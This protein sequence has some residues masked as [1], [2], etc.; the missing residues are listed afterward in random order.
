MPR[1]STKILLLINCGPLVFPW[2]YVHVVSVFPRSI[3]QVLPAGGR[4]SLR[5][6]FRAEYVIKKEKKNPNFLP[7]VISVM[8]LSFNHLLYTVISCA[9][10]RKSLKQSVT[11]S[12]F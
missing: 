8:M 6:N 4:Q 10:K 5:T 9:H 2:T 1:N 11:L 7:A 12:G 3:P